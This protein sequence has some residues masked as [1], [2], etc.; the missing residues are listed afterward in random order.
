MCA[1]KKNLE[2][3]TKCQQWLSSLGNSTG[4][5]FYFLF[6]FL[7]F[8]IFKYSTMNMYY[9][10]KKEKKTIMIVCGLGWAFYFSKSPFLEPPMAPAQA[11]FLRA[12]WRE[13][14]RWQLLPNKIYSPVISTFTILFITNQKDLRAVSFLSHPLTA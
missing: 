11:P 8:G 12:Q 10:Y 3:N 14:D 2:G 6:F 13:C 9:F 4:E 7:L 1:Q 5:C